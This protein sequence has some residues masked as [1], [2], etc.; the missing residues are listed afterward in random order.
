MIGAI[1]RH[2]LNGAKNVG[3][4]STAGAP[5]L[6]QGLLIPLKVESSSAIQLRTEK[7]GL[8]PFFTLAESSMCSPWPASVAGVDRIVIPLLPFVQTMRPIL[9]AYTK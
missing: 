7:I 1:P 8:K 4:R 3:A 6:H 2:S 9:V 5:K